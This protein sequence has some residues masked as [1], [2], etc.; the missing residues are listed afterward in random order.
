MA[1]AKSGDGNV[2]GGGEGSSS[3]TGL[4]FTTLVLSLREAALLMLGALD[5]PEHGVEPDPAGAKYQIDLL[6]LLQ[7]KTAGNLTD[8]EDKLLRTVLYELRT[9]YLEYRR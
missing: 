2:G 6:G 9:A 8:D 3:S 4:D 7:D 1:E 5:A